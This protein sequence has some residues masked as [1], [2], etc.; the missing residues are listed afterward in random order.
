[1][2][3]FLFHYYA[4]IIDFLNLNLTIIACKKTKNNYKQ[5]KNKKCG[6]TCTV[7]LVCTLVFIM[8]VVHII[9]CLNIAS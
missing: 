9:N 3:Y 7:V 1:M 8:S 5:V 2:S 6:Q 4:F